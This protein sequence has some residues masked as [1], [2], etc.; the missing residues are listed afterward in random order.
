MLVPCSSEQIVLQTLK[1]CHAQHPN[2]NHQV[3]AYRLKTDKGFLYRCSDAGEPTG[4]AGKPVLQHLEGKNIVNALL[5]V[6]RY[7]G[8]IKLGAGGLTRAYS[9]TARTSY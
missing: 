1:K 5:V 7:F 8:G 2:A 6:V 9:Q 4:T 3:Y